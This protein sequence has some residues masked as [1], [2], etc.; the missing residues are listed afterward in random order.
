[1]GWERKICFLPGPTC[2]A[3]RR[4]FRPGAGKRRLRPSSRGLQWLGVSCRPA[5][6]SPHWKIRPTGK[7]WL[8]R[9]S[10]TIL[11]IQSLEGMVSPR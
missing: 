9:A 10:R 11:P 7:L 3:F 8:G 5:H 1:M 6:S 4:R 2:F